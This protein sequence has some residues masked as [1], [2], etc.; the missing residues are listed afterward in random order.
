VAAALFIVHVMHVRP[1]S[2]IWC[3]GAG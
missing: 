1:Q 3:S 2:C